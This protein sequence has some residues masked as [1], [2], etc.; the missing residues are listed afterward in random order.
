ME[1]RL[2]G[3]LCTDYDFDEI[4]DCGISFEFEYKGNQYWC[5][6]DRDPKKVFID[7][8]PD[9]KNIAEYTTKEFYQSK[10]F[11]RPIQDVIA[12]SY[13]TYIG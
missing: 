3:W 1:K 4:C 11:G 5:C 8:L 12:D 10:L 13:I 9:Y 6:T 2:K 7:T